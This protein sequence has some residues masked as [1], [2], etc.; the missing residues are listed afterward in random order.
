[1]SEVRVTVV[2]AAFNALEE[3]RQTVASVQEQDVGDI[4]HV[5]VDGGSSDGTSEYLSSIGHR[6]RWVSETDEGIAD[7]LNK[8]VAI[9]QGDYILVL[10]AGDRFAAKESLTRALPYLAKGFDI[11]AFEV[12]LLDNDGRSQIR[13]SR[14]FGFRTDLRM[15]NPHQGMFCR[16]DLFERIGRFDTNLRIAMDYDFLLRA[17]HAGAELLAVSEVVSVMPKT[18][19]STQRDWPSVRRRLKEDRMLQTRYQSGM[20]AKAVHHAFWALYWPYKF[21]KVRLERSV[22]G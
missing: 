21:M 15:T 13:G 19:V 16:R 14:P 12:S 22:H 2:T 18:G 3:L 8:G 17:K 20:V 11:V 5:V 10:Q 7:A 4:E 6:V 9:A 1:M